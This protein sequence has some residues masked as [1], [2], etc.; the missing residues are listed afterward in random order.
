MTTLATKNPQEVFVGRGIKTVAV[1]GSAAG[2]VAVHED[3]SVE[4]PA[5]FFVSVGGKLRKEDALG[6]PGGIFLFAHK[7]E[8]T[9][10][11]KQLA[12]TVCQIA[13]RMESAKTFARGGDILMQRHQADWDRVVGRYTCEVCE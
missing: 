8:T 5:R 4:S 13:K 3:R 6:Y 11:A 1:Y 9:R 7:A 12:E 10:K 2:Q